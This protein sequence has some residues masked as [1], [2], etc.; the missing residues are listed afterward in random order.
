MPPSPAPPADLAE[1][2]SGAIA[3]N[4]LFGM[5]LRP[6]RQASP[7]LA[8]RGSLVV[9]AAVLHGRDMEHP[10]TPSRPTWAAL[11]G[12]GAAV[13][14]AVVLLASGLA[15]S[16][17]GTYAGQVIMEG[18]LPAAPSSAG[19]TPP[20]HHGAG[21]RAARHGRGPDAAAHRQPGGAV[22]RPAVRAHSAGRADQPALRSWGAL[23]NRRVTT[24]TAIVVTAAV[25]GLNGVLLCLAVT[26]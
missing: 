8:G 15:S 17:V 1:Y 10:S 19:R 12:R 2:L 9:A 5:P 22:R 11:L 26:A 13:A 3:L 18:F 25:I 4:L 6:R 20:G 7:H 14:F 16:S 24:A 23:V 21:F